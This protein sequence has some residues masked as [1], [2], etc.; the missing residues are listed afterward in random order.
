MPYGTF[1]INSSVTNGVVRCR[2]FP[3]VWSSGFCL[4]VRRCGLELLRSSYKAD[5]CTIPLEKAEAVVKKCF[6]LLVTTLSCRLQRRRQDPMLKR[7]GG[8]ERKAPYCLSGCRCSQVRTCS[9]CAM[10]PA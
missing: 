5:S 3:T 9:V 1:S 10:L 4:A 8:K 7:R 2:S 6:E